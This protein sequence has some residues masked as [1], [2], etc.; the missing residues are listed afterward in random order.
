VTKSARPSTGHGTGVLQARTIRKQDTRLKTG[1][2][3]SSKD[4]RVQHDNR[5]RAA[6]KLEE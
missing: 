5:L 2:V 3:L 4:R 6:G 1:A